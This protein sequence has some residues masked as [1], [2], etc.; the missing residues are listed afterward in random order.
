MDIIVGTGSVYRPDICVRSLNRR[1]PQSSR[2][3]NSSGNPYPTL[4]VEIGNTERSNSLHELA[5]KYFLNG[6]LSKFI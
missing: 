1:Q 2:A 5:E 6:Q 3:V 4:V